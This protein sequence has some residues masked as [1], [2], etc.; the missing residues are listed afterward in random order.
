MVDTPDSG[1]Y[2][3]NLSVNQL[4]ENIAD[5]KMPTAR[6]GSTTLQQASSEKNNVTTKSPDWL[7]PIVTMPSRDF[8]SSAR[9]IYPSEHKYVALVMSSYC[10]AA[11]FDF[12]HNHG[13]WQTK[14]RRE[15]K[16]DQPKLFQLE[17]GGFPESARDLSLQDWLVKIQRASRWNDDDA[18]GERDVHD[19][20]S[21]GNLFSRMPIICS[22]LDHEERLVIED[23]EQILLTSLELCRQ[24]N[25]WNSFRL[26]QVFWEELHKPSTEFDL[27]TVWRRLA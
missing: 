3:R 14:C 8:E 5:S 24:L 4:S 21:L 18:I 1:N 27:E 22:L 10:E 20:R 7:K 15:D 23:F 6:S 2:K 9:C 13:L 26:L 25:G 16:E 19:F 12:Y 17:L 11:C